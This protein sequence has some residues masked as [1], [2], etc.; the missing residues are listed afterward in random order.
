MGVTF[1]VCD[2]CTEAFTDHDSD[3][4]IC[5]C[6]M[7]YCSDCF[8]EAEKIYGNSEDYSA[9]GYNIK[10]CYGCDPNKLPSDLE[11][12]KIKA[13]EIKELYNCDEV[14]TNFIDSFLKL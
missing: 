2:S 5:K 4:G 9:D 14:L 6:G 3:Y 13:K 12:L 8:P 11:L 7:Q 10:I 1:L